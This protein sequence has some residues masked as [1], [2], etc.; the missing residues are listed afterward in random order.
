MKPAR[1]IKIII[2][3]TL[4]GLLTDMRYAHAFVADIGFPDFSSRGGG[5]NL[6]SFVTD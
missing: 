1:S 2:E 4:W 6:I 5:Q 3:K